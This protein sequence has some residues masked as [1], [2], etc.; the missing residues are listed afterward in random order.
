MTW[1]NELIVQRIARINEFFQDKSWT[2]VTAYQF[3][4][5]ALFLHGLYII[6]DFSLDAQP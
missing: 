4:N 5:L 2:P 1:I 3:D 6:R